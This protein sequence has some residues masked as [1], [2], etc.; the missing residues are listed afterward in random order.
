MLP[1]PTAANC[2]Q[3]ALLMTLCQSG[4]IRDGG[5]PK[6]S[7]LLKGMTSLDV[8]SNESVKD[9]QIDWNGS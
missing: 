2:V 3:D 9:R 7:A 5:N 1:L 6:L 4:A 8:L